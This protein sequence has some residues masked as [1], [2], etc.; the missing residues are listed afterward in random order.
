MHF[1]YL[2][3][4]AGLIRVMQ[5]Q[6]TKHIKRASLKLMEIIKDTEVVS[7]YTDEN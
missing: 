6:R 1:H 5:F 3:P 4:F 7:A 2:I